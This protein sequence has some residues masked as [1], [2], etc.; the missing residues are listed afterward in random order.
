M[1]FEPIL[2]PSSYLRLQQV[3]DQRFHF[4]LE[5]RETLAGGFALETR[6]NVFHQAVTADVDRRRVSAEIVQLR[7]LLFSIFIRPGVQDRVLD[8]EASGECSELSDVSRRVAGVFERE[9]DHFQPP[10]AVAVVKLL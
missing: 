5:P 4:G 7:K 2:S 8:A 9:R 1:V 10:I 6:V 3:N